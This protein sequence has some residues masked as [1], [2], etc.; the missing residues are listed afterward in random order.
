MR[1]LTSIVVLFAIANA[2]E[3]Q[4]KSRVQEKLRL[5]V[6]SEVNDQLAEDYDLS[7]WGF[8]DKLKNKANEV[9][10]NIKRRA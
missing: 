2:A 5:L 1:V 10:E 4:S 9:R 8:F 6:L 3:I 7:E